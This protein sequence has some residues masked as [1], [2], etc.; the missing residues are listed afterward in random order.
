MASPK[1]AIIGGKLLLLL[2]SG[3]VLRVKINTSKPALLA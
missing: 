3:N 2:L 1:I